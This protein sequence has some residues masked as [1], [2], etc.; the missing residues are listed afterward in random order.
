MHTM[1]PSNPQKKKFYSK[2]AKLLETF[3]YLNHISNINYWIN[4][5][6]Q[7]HRWFTSGIYTKAWC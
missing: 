4:W 5:A 6:T 7:L 3:H 2:I 1:L